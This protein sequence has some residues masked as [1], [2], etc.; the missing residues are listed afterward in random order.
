MKRRISSQG[1]EFSTAPVDTATGMSLSHQFN[2]PTAGATVTGYYGSYYSQY[3]DFY[4]PADHL[5]FSTHH[6]PPHGPQH[7]PYSSFPAA[8]ASYGML[9][10]LHGAGASG[11]V[12][13]YDPAGSIEPIDSGLPPRF[14]VT[15]S[16]PFRRLP[17]SAPAT[18]DVKPEAAMRA[19]ES[20]TGR[21]DCRTACRELRSDVDVSISF[22][23]LAS[24]DSWL[25]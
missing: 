18:V 7:G 25:P 2:S 13:W 10:A 6:T 16:T 19:T 15:G 9:T 14:D 23:Q 3:P 20:G 21:S 24:F 22:V 5:D 12:P 8:A 4:G 17:V 11:A 1:E